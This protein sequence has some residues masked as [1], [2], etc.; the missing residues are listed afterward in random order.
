MRSWNPAD[1]VRG[2]EA[3]GSQGTL[4]DG[5]GGSRL[6]AGAGGRDSLGT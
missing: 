1:R 3:G 4:G 6:E 5:D 2:M